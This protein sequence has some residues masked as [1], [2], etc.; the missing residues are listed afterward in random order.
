M[1]V[2]PTLLG[3]LLNILIDNACKYSP[4]GTPITIRLLAVGKTARVDVEDQGCGIAA[5]DLPYLF[6]PF[7]RSLETRRLGIEGVGL[8]LSIARRLAQAFG[9][10]LTVTSQVGQGSCLCLRLPL[11]NSSAAKEEAASPGDLCPNR[12]IEP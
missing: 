8:G 4:P 2:H 11:T 3:E 5:A 6:T 7:F 1:A 9:G 10:E 12:Q